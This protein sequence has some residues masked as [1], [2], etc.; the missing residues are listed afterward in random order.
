MADIVRRDVNLAK[1]L[2]LGKEPR[3]LSVLRSI[4]TGAN[5]DKTDLYVN[6]PLPWFDLSLLSNLVL[7]LDHAKRSC[8]KVHINLGESPS[9]SRLSFLGQI[10]FWSVL[11][12]N[13]TGSNITCAPVPDVPS[14]PLATPTD[15]TNSTRLFTSLLRQPSDRIES[16]E[17]G[18]WIKK[19]DEDLTKTIAF[20]GILGSQLAWSREY[21]YRVLWELVVNSNRHS[22]EEDGTRSDSDK[23]AIIGQVFLHQS[24][25]AECRENLAHQSPRVSE[26]IERRWERIAGSLSKQYE[27][28]IQHST[29]LPSR[30]EWLRR[31]ANTSFL[32][33]TCVDLGLGIPES[34]AARGVETEAPEHERLK[35]AFDPDHSLG[36]SEGLDV[37]GLAQLAQLV[38]DYDGYMHFR[39]GTGSVEACRRTDAIANP[40]VSL[41]GT[42][43]QVLLPVSPAPSHVRRGTSA[44][45]SIERVRSD[46]R[47]RQPTK[48]VLVVKDVLAN[49]GIDVRT[50]KDAESDSAISRLV[51]EAKELDGECVYVDV[52]CVPHDRQFLSMAL[53]RIR[54]A[55]DA[56]GRRGLIVVN[57]SP[58]LMEVAGSLTKVDDPPEGHWARMDARLS[59]DTTRGMPL[60]DLLPLLLPV[61]CCTPPSGRRGSEWPVSVKWLGLS[62]LR[63]DIRDA[64]ILLLNHLFDHIGESVSIGALADLWLS[65]DGSNEARHKMR[66][67][68]ASQMQSLAHRHP[69]IV[70]P[71]PDDPETFSLRLDP[72]TVWDQSL[73]IIE[74]RVHAL[75]LTAEHK[76]EEKGR[77]YRFVWHDKDREFREKY[78]QAWPVLSQYTN[79]SDVAE[80]LLR[81]AHVMGR[82]V[83]D[84]EAVVAV[85][86]SAGLLAREIA[87]RLGVDLWEVPSIYDIDQAEWL[88]KRV[89]KFV[90]VDDV[91]D[92]GYST[93][94]LRNCVKGS[95]GECIGV[96]AFFRNS[97][98]AAEQSADVIWADQIQLGRVSPEEAKGKEYY[99][100]DPH[101]LEPIHDQDE[102]QNRCVQE[103]EDRLHMLA[104]AK[105]IRSGHFVFGN[106][107]Y[108]LYFSLADALQSTES[109]EKMVAWVQTTLLTTP[110]L[111]NRKSGFGND[112][113]IVYP[114]YSPVYLLVDRLRQNWGRE[115]AGHDV[116]FV[117]AQPRQLSGGRLGY[118]IKQWPA[119]TRPALAVFIDDGI[120]SGE[121]LAGITDA[122]LEHGPS[123][124]EIIVIFDRIGLRTRRHMNSVAAYRCG[125][126]MAKGRR[127][128]LRKIPSHFHAFVR[129]GI[130]AEKQRDCHQCMVYRDLDRL[131]DRIPWFAESMAATQ[132]KR[133]FAT[134]VISAS[135]PS[136]VDRLSRWDA[137][138]VVKFRAKAFSNEVPSGDI[139]KEL[140]GLRGAAQL[141]AAVALLQD[142]K[143]YR[144]TIRDDRAA[145][146]N[147]LRN[148]LGDRSL[149]ADARCRFLLQ[150]AYAAD[151]H[152]AV[153]FLKDAVPD[154]V[155]KL[156]QHEGLKDAL[157]EQDEALF[158]A[159]LAA[160]RLTVDRYATKKDERSRKR[161]KLRAAWQALL[162]GEELA[163]YRCWL[164]EVLADQPLEESRL[165]AER[166]VE[167]VRDYALVGRNHP[168]GPFADL[169]WVVRLLAGKVNAEKAS[170]ATEWVSG[171]AFARF[172]KSISY[173]TELSNYRSISPTM[174]KRLRDTDKR[175]REMHQSN[176][177]E[178]S[179]RDD[180][181]AVAEGLQGMG[182]T[183]E[184]V[185][186]GSALAQLVESCLMTPARLRKVCGRWENRTGVR[187]DVHYQVNELENLVI[188]ERVLEEVTCELL[189]N[190]LDACD[191]D[192]PRKFRPAIIVVQPDHVG[193]ANGTCADGECLEI[194]VEDNVAMPLVDVERVWE[195]SSG[196]LRCKRQVNRWLGDIDGF[197]VLE[198]D[199]ARGIALR[200]YMRITLRRV[201]L[202]E[203]EDGV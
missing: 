84:A 188:S 187:V 72:V 197:H 137:L 1:P 6:W 28:E 3:D 41:G 154:A 201:R 27:L 81:K 12:C 169:C 90:I 105:A 128:K 150:I 194:R 121:T 80:L 139:A 178:E 195:G 136:A 177:A 192:Q 135:R 34:L 88:P 140:V 11:A 181:R 56:R 202:P 36:L 37:H 173:A 74:Q 161:Q 190:A 15:M 50:M 104:K 130:R 132:L 153:E 171:T 191:D 47:Q 17:M 26:R 23:I 146:S 96:L 158:L 170:L 75:R 143:L 52:M 10:G 30:R 85:T 19:F 63:A 102:P 119:T 112:I 141:D 180:A 55:L 151:E 148:V 184:G 127:E 167:L 57:A 144:Q 86:P 93:K 14:D 69:W 106:N 33:L 98:E 83:L 60:N 113:V 62:S 125:E 101:T 61:T 110:V 182:V 22:S 159:V 157:A 160:L 71:H 99:L 32:L 13:E 44:A 54:Y 124:F 48:P 89:G 133:L 8:R 94:R 123:G 16:S 175:W 164:N 116:H 40:S 78:Y 166:T 29:G 51:E 35:L 79:R 68:V 142:Q 39:S 4:V 118:S 46:F 108:E 193:A 120:A 176:G 162:K 149:S 49:A 18:E 109:A 43:A 186:S 134:Q 199:S 138:S 92:T 203:S 38:W 25:L 70:K 77:L 24:M 131:Q 179:W 174:L 87:R 189:S 91:Y 97:D 67:T 117:V 7:Q 73:G 126:G 200:K 66:Q 155:K 59:S 95:G 53:R 196:L 185:E 45:V 64:V 5:A 163:E 100:V 114:Y 42:L 2:L 129:A 198:T 172:M 115:L 147:M 31:H 145:V 168:V 65:A 76:P 20:H 58:G 152:F 9:I 82:S 107:H 122:V 165:R 183:R 156:A 21:I 111:S 103:N